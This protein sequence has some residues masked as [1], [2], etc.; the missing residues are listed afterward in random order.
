MGNAV[1]KVTPKKRKSKKQITIDAIIES[2]QN[3]C[4]IVKACNA[5]GITAMSFWRWR[6]KDEK[7][8]ERYNEAIN[9]RIL[10]AEDALYN[11]VLEGNVTAQ[12]FWLTNRVSDRWQDRRNVAMQHSGQISVESSMPSSSFK[13]P[14]DVGKD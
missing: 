14:D 13:K 4:S 8:A 6:Q 9:A 1:T 7:L 3:G 5:A 10:V 11:N 12:I 2:V